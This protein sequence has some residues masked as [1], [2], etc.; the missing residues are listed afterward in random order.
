MSA[1]LCGFIWASNLH[2]RAQSHCSSFSGTPLGGENCKLRPWPEWSAGHEQLGLL[3][4]LSA[5][6][7][8]LMTGWKDALFCVVWLNIHQSNRMGKR[9]WTHRDMLHKFPFHHF[10]HA[11]FYS[12]TVLVLYTIPPPSH[13]SLFQI[14][15][16]C[17]WWT[18]ASVQVL[19]HHWSTLWTCVLPSC[20]LPS[21][22]WTLWRRCWFI[23]CW[24][25]ENDPTSEYPLVIYVLLRKHFQLTFRVFVMSSDIF[26]VIAVNTF[27]A[28]ISSHSTVV[29]SDLLQ[30]QQPFMLFCAAG[31]DMSELKINSV[32][33]LITFCRWPSRWTNQ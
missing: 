23:S 24:L 25:T 16:L 22:S 14:L 31:F 20:T 21:P 32:W 1:R 33:G 28:Y 12:V 17:A 2:A 5:D 4:S 10:N 9:H 13:R 6:G 18:A 15:V 11:S 29:F 26:S 30:W 27:G 7:S 8:T 3:H 19:T